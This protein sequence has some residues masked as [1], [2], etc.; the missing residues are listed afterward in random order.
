M[1]A[2]AGETVRRA[3]RDAERA[4][5]VDRPFNTSEKRLART[6]P[7]RA[8]YG[9][10]DPARRVLPENSQQ[11]L[12]GMVGTTRSRVNL[13]M[14]TSSRL[15]FVEYNGALTVNDSLLSVVLHA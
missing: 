4:D 14:H 12:A 13:F 2:R 6:R 7:L 5:L 15:G 10:P 8:R 9:K 3:S 1:P 11:T